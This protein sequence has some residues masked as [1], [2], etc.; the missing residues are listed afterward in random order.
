M[1]VRVIDDDIMGPTRY[2][3]FVNIVRNKAA[4]LTGL[5]DKNV[6]TILGS[7]LQQLNRDIAASQVKELIFAM[8][9][10][11]DAVAG[12]DMMGL[13]NWWSGM[14]NIPEDLS[15]FAKQQQ[16]AGQ[17]GI[18]GMQGMPTQSAPPVA[19]PTQV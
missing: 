18:P 19:M 4:D 2:A 5:D 1:A 17:P 15:K 10:N 16:P 13:I 3:S 14:L 9:Q 11:P 8:L 12:T 6:M 7:G